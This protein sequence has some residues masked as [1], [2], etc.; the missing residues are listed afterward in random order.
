MMAHNARELCMGDLCGREDIKP[1]MIV[2]YH[3]ESHRRAERAIGVLTGAVRAMLRDSGLPDSLC[4]ETFC[5]AAYVHNRTL[6]KVLDLIVR[7]SLRD[8]A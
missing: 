7:D 1:H 5:T 3:P 4:V 2:L 8:R 6:T